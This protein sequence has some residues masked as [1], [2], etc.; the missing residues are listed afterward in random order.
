MNQADLER[1]ILEYIRR[2]G[3][4]PVKPRVIAKQ[5]GISADDMVEVRRV[6]K[7]LVRGGELVYGSNH[8]LGYR[9]S[10]GTHE[11]P[12]TQSSPGIKSSTP[13]KEHQG[14]LQRTSAGNG[15]V[16][17][18]EDV[19]LRDREQDIY[20]P[21]NK[22][23]DAADGD[24][25]AISISRQRRGPVMKRVG[26]VLQV[27]ERRTYQ[28]VGT[29]LEHQD[30]HGQ[31]LVQLD[32]NTFP[33]PIYVGDPGAKN[34][35]P[36]DK[37]VIEMVRFPTP[38]RTGE[39]VIL[40]VLGA[41]S[42]PG[43]DTEMVMYE[44]NLPREFPEEVLNESRAVAARFD[45]NVLP[46]DRD[47]L[48]GLT[49]ITIDP[50]TARD[51]DDA[52]SLQLTPEGNWLLGVHI[53][54]VAH[55]VQPGGAIDREARERGT[56][57]Y[58]PD[59]VIPMLPEV[60]SNNLA[61]LQP[62]RVRLTHSAMMEFSP[63]GERLKVRTQRSAIRSCRR[64]TY[65]EIDEYLSDPES[66]RKKLTD[67]VWLLVKN[68]NS[69]AMRIRE[70][71]MARGSIELTMPET[72]LELDDRGQVQDAKLALNTVSHQIIEEFMLSANEAVAETLLKRRA[73]FLHR[74]HPEPSPKKL[75][76][77][78][79][80]LRHLGFDVPERCDRFD[81]KRVLAAVAGEPL[82]K[83]VNLTILKSMQKAVYGPSSEGHYALASE[84]Y[85]HFTS[86]IRRYPDLIVHRA[87]TG[88]NGAPTPLQGM[89]NLSVLGDH[90]SERE[91]R[92]EKAERELV[93][94]K[95][96]RYFA[97]HVGETFR[98]LVTGVESFG[99]FVQCS[100]I[101]GEGRIARESLREDHFEFHRPSM[102][103]VGR[104]SGKSFQ[105]GDLVEVQVARID[106]LQRL[107]E[108]A[109]VHHLGP[110]Y[111]PK[112]AARSAPKKGTKKSAEESGSPKR[113]KGARKKVSGNKPAGKKGKGK[114]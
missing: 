82:E 43:V 39:G 25:V 66:W 95:L 92:A 14:R 22:C 13:A 88:E 81:L 99:V 113:P 76:D 29:Y 97:K 2:P 42:K 6:I 35:R 53:A 7:H 52:I 101:P 77:L 103:L 109:Y 15:Y 24:L 45:E 87:L 78:G 34:V 57:V 72:V 1:R 51:F 19:P 96:I 91:Q 98:A 55:F 18:T 26:E 36:N 48:T 84:A 12:G 83:P 11:T 41:R 20:I 80:F 86:P 33:A 61:S 100:P 75:A 8:A 3:Y 46:E 102:S 58:L 21:S 112:Q 4:Q 23:K 69:L 38:L 64:F 105:I 111:K 67:E 32:G 9:A 60:I 47:D 59:R 44:F 56:S 27:I 40:Q 106:E 73:P 30:P 17:L 37:V 90:C 62:N 50:I 104:R 65:E 108:F 89:S 28:F 54:D 16:R 68:M 10:Q 94:L 114:R 85:C 110:H 31:A 93:R 5:L 49:V 79:V 70:R 107:I 63:E 71:R 74:V